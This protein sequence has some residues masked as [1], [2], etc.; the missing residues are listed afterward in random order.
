MKR[1]ELLQLK[2][3]EFIGKSFTSNKGE[4]LTITEY[5]NSSNVTILFEDGTIRGNITID[6]VKKG[7]VKNPNT[8]TIFNIAF[9]GQGEYNCKTHTKFY[10]LW[11]SMLTRCYSNGN[12]TYKGCSV[13]PDWH[14][15][16]NFAK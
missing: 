3:K 1:D 4:T 9:I 12:P 5:V 2:R 13:H 15:F 8:S 7:I 6:S 14:N 16:Q 10:T 11:S